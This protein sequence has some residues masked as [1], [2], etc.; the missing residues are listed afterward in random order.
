MNDFCPELS[1][2]GEAFTLEIG[3]GEEDQQKGNARFPK[4]LN[5]EYRTDPLHRQF[6]T[7]S[8]A[9]G[10]I[11]DSVASSHSRPQRC[12]PGP[13]GRIVIWSG[14]STPR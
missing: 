4:S 2:V 12:G 9:A 5:A 3:G 14:Q 11:C 6:C 13:W 10:F 7:V 8:T 1:V